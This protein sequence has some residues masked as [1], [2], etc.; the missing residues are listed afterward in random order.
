MISIIM[1]SYTHV[2]MQKEIKGRAFSK[3]YGFP[4][5]LKVFINAFAFAF[6]RNK[7]FAFAFKC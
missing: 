2:Y 4:L 1:I 6:E 3:C 7:T 5:H